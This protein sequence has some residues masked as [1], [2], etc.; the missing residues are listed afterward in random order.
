MLLQD[1][2]REIDLLFQR[3]LLRTGNTTRRQNSYD[4]RQAFERARSLLRTD[5][6]EEE[7]LLFELR[8]RLALHLSPAEAI[9]YDSKRTTPRKRLVSEYLQRSHGC[10]REEADELSVDIVRVLRAWDE[11]RET[12]TGYVT[13][14]LAS[15]GFRCASC[16]V[17]LAADSLLLVET[18]PPYTLQRKDEFKPYH[19]APAELLA[20]EVDHIQP[21]SRLGSNQTMNL[22]VLCRSCN[23][24]KGDRLGLDTRTEAAHAAQPIVSIPRSLR[25]SMAYYVFARA[26]GAC[27]LCECSDAELTVRKLHADGGYLRSNLYSICV[28]CVE[29]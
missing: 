8:L 4:L 24:G 13:E 9:T 28:R 2:S 5:R 3:L 18:R 14:L 16:N 27:E 29:G 7:S 17:T 1:L 6:E 12:V 20:A 19:L 22:Q 11:R 10:S 25:A 23:S 21:I 26:A 15:Q